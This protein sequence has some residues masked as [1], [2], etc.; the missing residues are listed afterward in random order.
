MLPRRGRIIVCPYCQT[1]VPAELT[2]L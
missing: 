1:I 2:N